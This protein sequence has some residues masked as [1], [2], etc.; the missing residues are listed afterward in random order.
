[1]SP[2]SFSHKTKNGGSVSIVYSAI[3]QCETL[4]TVEESNE[5]NFNV[6]EA[7]ST[8]IHPVSCD[9]PLSQGNS[10][11]G[12]I[13]IQLSQQVYAPGDSVPVIVDFSTSKPVSHT[14]VVLIETLTIKEG[15]RTFQNSTIL[16]RKLCSVK[17]S[18]SINC[19][20]E[21]PENSNTSVLGTLITLQHKITA[22][23]HVTSILPQEFEVSVPIT[24][25]DR[26]VL[27]KLPKI[28]GLK[29]EEF[30]VPNNAGER[31]TNTN[32]TRLIP[33]E[34]IKGNVFYKTSSVFYC[35]IMEDITALSFRLQSLKKVTIK[36]KFGEEPKAFSSDVTAQEL[37]EGKYVI[38][39]DKYSSPP[40]CPGRW[41]F[42]ITGSSFM[43]SSTF[44]ALLLFP[45]EDITETESNIEVIHEFQ[46][47]SS[48]FSS[49]SH[50]TWKTESGEDSVCKEDICLP[51]SKWYWV[52]PWKLAQAKSNRDNLGWEYATNA[53]SNQWKNQSRAI[54]LIRRRVWK[55]KRAIKPDDYVEPSLSDAEEELDNLL[56]EFEIVSDSST[57]DVIYISPDEDFSDNNKKR[58]PKENK[59]KKDEIIETKQEEPEEIVELDLQF[60]EDDDDEEEEA[61]SIVFTLEDVERANQLALEEDEE[62]SITIT[63][64]QIILEQERKEEERRKKEEEE[65]KRLEEEREERKKSL[66]QQRQL[67]KEKMEREWQERQDA[68]R[69]QLEQDQ[70]RLQLLQN[71]NSSKYEKEESS[72]ENIQNKPSI[73]NTK[74]FE[75]DE[76]DDDFDDFEP[77]D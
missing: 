69:M 18:K 62:E 66:Q 67:E 44:Q 75:D 61:E 55:R 8:P 13:S 29:N 54:F 30:S 64:S 11:D 9:N 28:D 68:L 40:I 3:A 45:T 12:T 20:L 56:E 23:I 53:N 76:D 52:Y 39:L 14:T 25:C 47:R 37:S 22:T 71:S 27:E 2:S 57:P 33:K 74:E 6:L 5:I 60:G 35:D 59:K 32:G 31:N 50:S 38:N 73:T 4:E 17:D 36:G 42:T 21:I 34:P 72:S 77:V 49:W 58:K 15:E 1:M 63:E 48:P 16:S 41:F 26:I 10:K 65:F 7:Y 43:Q 19:L 46:Q 70:K 24:L 51:D